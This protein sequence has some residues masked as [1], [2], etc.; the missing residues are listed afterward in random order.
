MKVGKGGGTEARDR[1][2][3]SIPG[4]FSREDHGEGVN[5]ELGE[6]LSLSLSLSLS[7]T[8]PHG[9]RRTAA[10]SPLLWQRV[11]LYDTRAA[12]PRPFRAT[13]M[14][15]GILGHNL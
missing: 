6:S 10:A 9:I 5:Y 3:V 13:R 12:A 1:P 4:S 7:R 14:T 15:A 8:G 2:A 11:L